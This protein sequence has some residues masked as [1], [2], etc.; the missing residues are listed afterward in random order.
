MMR[1][2]LVLTTLLLASCS[3]ARP[4]AGPTTSPTIVATEQTSGATGMGTEVWEGTVSSRV[5]TV[6]TP[7]GPCG[8]PTTAEG[9][10]RW[11]VAEDGSVTGTYDVDGCLVSEPH[12]EFTGTATEDGF[13][14]PE[15]IVLTNG[16]LIP[17][18]SPTEARA[19]LTNFQGSGGV[20]ARWVTTWEITC[21]T[22]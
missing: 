11:M 21:T 16:E 19:T 20:G 3:Q 8:S 18:I 6:G 13:T 5:F 12:A 1:R 17:K 10:T 15:L 4:E 2:L 14:F 22:C 7:P 9:T